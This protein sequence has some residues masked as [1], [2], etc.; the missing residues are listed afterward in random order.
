MNAGETFFGTATEIYKP[1]RKAP[2]AVS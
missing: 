2:E 1:K